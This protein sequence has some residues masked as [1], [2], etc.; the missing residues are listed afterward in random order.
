M[1]LSSAGSAPLDVGQIAVLPDDGTLV[2]P[3]NFFDLHQ[4][5]L[6]FTPKTGV[7]AV[8]VGAL[9]FDSSAVQQGILLNP[10]PA[11]HPNNIGDDGTRAVNL[12]FVFPFF[13]ENYTSVFINSDGNLTFQEG[14]T[15]HSKRSLSRILSGPPRIAPYFVDLDP[16]VGGELRY[17][18]SSERLVV[19][20]SA[21]PDYRESGVGPRE[22]FQVELLPDGSIQFSYNGI[23]GREAVVGVTPGASLGSVELLDL[24]AATGQ[25]AS[26]GS[27]AEIFSLS[28]QLDLLAV[29]RRF[30]E[31]H[32]D[33]YEFLVVFTT[34]DFNLDGAFAFAEIVSNNVTGIGR[35]GNPPVFDSA[36]SFGSSR[37]ETVLNMG[38]LLRYPQNP[39]EVF[40]GVNSTLSI[41]GQEAG[42]RFLSYVRWRDPQGPPDSTELLGRGLTHWSFFYNSD[43]SVVEGNRIRDNGDGTFTTTGVVE[44]YSAL[45]QY[46]MGLRSPEETPASFLVKDPISAFT[47]SR[48]PQLNATFSGRRASVT[49]DQI[50]AANGPRVPNSVIA[51]KTFNFAFL[52]V[53]PRNTSPS[54][55]QVAHLDRIRR[56]WEPFFTQATASRAAA[57]TDLL[58]SLRWT[59][60]PLGLITGTQAEA[61]VGLLAAPASDLTVTLTNS[62][63]LIVALPPRVVVPAGSRSAPVPVTALAPG[64]A[65]VS[66]TAPGFETSTAVVEVLAAPAS[67]GL[68]LSI[69]SGDRQIASPWTS[70][71]QPLRVVLRDGNT[72]PF[73][74]V[75][76]EFAVTQ[77][78]ASLNVSG[79][80]TDGQGRASANVT[81]GPETG[82]VRITAIV[83]GTLLQAQFT[84]FSAGVPV[85]PQTGVVHAASFLPGAASRGS[86]ISILG[87]NLAATTAGATSLPLPT[88]LAGASVE[89]GGLA[90]PLYFVSPT[91]INAQVPMELGATEVSL[92]VRNGASSSDPVTIV[93]RPA[94]P[95]IFTQ[96]GDGSG[97]G[98]ITHAATNFL[99]TPD[100]PASAGEVVQIYATGLGL[101]SPP[102]AS[103]SPAPAEPLSRT[104]SLVTVTMNGTPAPISFSGLAPGLA[105]VYRVDAQVPAG[106]RGTATVVVSVDGIASNGAT[107][108][109]R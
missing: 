2:S 14:D 57:R 65:A 94:S 59:P 103:G 22:T 27:I 33:A 104:V 43:A 69:E 75:R 55:A 23:N 90:A 60:S 67:G 12:G 15:A 68:A 78:D 10:P 19:S 35:I 56:E 28:A 77:G 71:P 88:G 42:H 44:Q 25:A 5:T 50:I 97:P 80:S 79:T 84:A 81:L 16:S 109:V 29:S 30:Y 17:L 37:L 66:A 106:I 64:R 46:L 108:E 61:Q 51:P 45:D 20:W 96:D 9:E 74:G 8:A 62:N 73:A 53:V 89:I 98:V 91:Q 52:L 58:L 82:P 101:V 4:L 76:V 54:D 40:H 93:A 13:G 107:M 100:R 87:V 11:S 102:V 105:G 39:R 49:V 31:T 3:A 99:V 18:S 86:I 83:P 34:F 36:G 32:D 63:P 72:I 41:L 85:V 70:L 21:V 1:P 24:S 95:G 6:T 26:A 7:Y 92:I 38:N 47:A 48:A